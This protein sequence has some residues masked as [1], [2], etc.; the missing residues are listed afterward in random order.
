MSDFD[1]IIEY[2]KQEKESH[3]KKRDK[4]FWARSDMGYA[5]ANGAVTAI[6]T[7]IIGLRKLKRN[8]QIDKLDNELVQAFELVPVTKRK[9]KR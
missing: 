8:G 6:V 4:Q 7:C 5:T 1:K 2:L 3:R 9:V